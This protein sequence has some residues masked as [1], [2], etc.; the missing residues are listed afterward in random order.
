VGGGTSSLTREHRYAAYKA[1]LMVV[2]CSQCTK[3]LYCS[4]CFLIQ[5]SI[6]EALSV[7]AMLLRDGPKKQATF[8]SPFPLFPEGR[9]ETCLGA[10][11]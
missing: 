3:V 10:P 11:W 5:A 8:F 7:T 6:T 2:S 4:K 9:N 1:S